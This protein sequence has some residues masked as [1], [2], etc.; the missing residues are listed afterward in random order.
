MSRPLPPLPDLEVSEDSVAKAADV[1]V[2]WINHGLSIAREITVNRNLKLF[3]QVWESL[4]NGFCLLSRVSC[5]P[6][7]FWKGLISF[8]L[9][10]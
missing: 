8:L 4:M 3:F 9:H 5:I 7:T 10:G 6:S 2:E 1:I